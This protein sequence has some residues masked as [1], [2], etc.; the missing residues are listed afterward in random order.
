[1]KVAF[2]T[3]NGENVA[4]HIGLAKHIAF[5]ELPEGKFI[6]MIEN[7]IVKK[8]KDDNIKINKD[9]EGARHMGVG[10]IIPAFL[11]EK[12]VDILVTYEFGRGVTENLLE[13]G[14][15]PIVPES[16]KIKDIIETLKNNQ[17]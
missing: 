11:K 17:G 3:N 15:T 5:Y 1:M 14:I 7:P 2:M 4:K 10:Y 12:S 16:H 6:E 8:I 9:N 13:L